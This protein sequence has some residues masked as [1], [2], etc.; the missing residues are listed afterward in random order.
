M[1]YKITQDFPADEKFG[2][3]SQIR[4]AT[5]SISSNIAEG[6][7]RTGNKNQGQFYQIAYSSTLEVLSQLI[8]ATELG[9]MKQEDLISCREK[10]ELITNRLNALRKSLNV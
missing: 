2:L 5:I 9:F 1:I 3:V 7:G 10:I 4:R 8:I 6:T